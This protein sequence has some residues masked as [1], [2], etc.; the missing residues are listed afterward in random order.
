VYAW[1]DGFILAELGD[2]LAATSSCGVR[3]PGR[4]SRM[5]RDEPDW[6]GTLVVAPIEL[7]ERD[8]SAN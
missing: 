1:G 2:H 3:T 7:D 8:F 5:L 6:A 4:R